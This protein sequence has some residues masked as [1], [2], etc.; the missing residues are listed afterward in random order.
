MN[1]RIG[2]DGRHVFSRIDEGGPAVDGRFG[3]NIFVLFP[4]D[5]HIFPARRRGDTHGESFADQVFHGLR[6]AFFIAHFFRELFF[7]DDV[8]EGED[9]FG[10]HGGAAEFSQG[11]AVGEIG[12]F[13]FP[14]LPEE[15]LPLGPHFGG[16]RRAAAELFDERG[17]HGVPHAERIDEG[18]VHVA[19]DVLFIFEHKLSFRTAKEG[20]F[21]PSFFFYSSAIAS[22]SARAS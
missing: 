5:L 16:L 17:I 20:S 9:V 3:E 6:R 22:S 14:E 10:S 12:I 1:F 2:L 13:F 8:A 7:G 18:A 11:S 4:V 15:A 19:D 21:L